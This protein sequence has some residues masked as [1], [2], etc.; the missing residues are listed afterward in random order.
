MA[1][2]EWTGKH[3]SSYTNSRRKIKTKPFQLMYVRHAPCDSSFSGNVEKKHVGSIH[4]FSRTQ[5]HAS[6]GG[7]PV[8]L[9]LEELWHTNYFGNVIVVRW[10]FDINGHGSYS[11]NNANNCH[12]STLKLHDTRLTNPILKRLNISEIDKSAIK[13]GWCSDFPNESKWHLEL[14]QPT[15]FVDKKT[16]GFFE[17]TVF[18]TWIAHVSCISCILCTL[19]P[20]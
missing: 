6:S 20:C 19:Q 2:R 4:G 12:H 5:I 3:F 14:G 11:S 7:A 13:A 10:M 17:D 18:Y 9:V 1:R 8:D 15:N 16:F